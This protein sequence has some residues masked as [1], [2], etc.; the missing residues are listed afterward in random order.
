[1]RVHAI[2]VRNLVT[3]E[4]NSGTTPDDECDTGKYFHL[5]VTPD[6]QGSA[7]GNVPKRYA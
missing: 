7:V 4:T 3:A 2:D 1:M 5:N 6:N